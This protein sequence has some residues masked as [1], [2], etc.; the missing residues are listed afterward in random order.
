MLVG[1]GPLSFACCSD[2]AADADVQESV[3]DVRRVRPDGA[4]SRGRAR[5]LPQL[6]DAA[7]DERPLPEPPLHR[8]RGVRGSPQPAPPLQPVGARGVGRGGR[9]H[10]GGRHVAARRLQDAAEHAGGV[11]A[12]G[13]GRGARGQGG[14]IGAAARG[15]GGVRKRRVPGVLSRDVGADHTP[16]AGDG[17]FVVGVR[18]LQVR[19]V[20][21]GGGAGRGRGRGGRRQLHRRGHGG[22]RGRARC[23]GDRF[24]SVIDRA[25]PPVC[26]ARFSLF[27]FRPE[28]ST[29]GIR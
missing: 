3:P 18:V 25:K 16:D 23:D 24:E 19:A 10:R 5:V 9:R 21:V 12:A 2:Q 26:R 8:L 27:G 14:D 17:D 28:L 11:R 6:H 4:A 22:R 7:R 15:E 29:T 13:R 1:V 20:D